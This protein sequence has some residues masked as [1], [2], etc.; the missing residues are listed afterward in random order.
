[1]SSS[2]SSIPTIIQ[3]YT[4]SLINPSPT[5]PVAGH[6][7]LSYQAVEVHDSVSS[8]SGNEEESTLF[9]RKQTKTSVVETP[10]LGVWNAKISS[11]TNKLADSLLNIPSSSYA[12]CMTVNLSNPSQVEPDMA[13]MQEALVRHLI[14]TSSTTTTSSTSL[15]QLKNVQFGLAPEDT[16]ASTSVVADESDR[17]IFAN[18][19]IC[20][21]LP[22]SKEE[23]DY[24]TTQAQNLVLYHV[25]RFAAAIGASL[26]FSNNRNDSTINKNSKEEENTPE[27]DKNQVSTLT[28]NQVA[29]VWREFALNQKLQDDNAAIYVS[30]SNN[31][32]ELVETVL[33]RNANNPPA[34]NSS[35]DS[36]WKA[37]PA[38]SNENEATD[39]TMKQGSS[40]NSGDDGWLQQL[41]DS[42]G[43]A[44]TEPATTTTTTT[45]KANKTEDAEVSSFFENLLKK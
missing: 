31:E 19:M 26:V 42:L 23:Q 25:R 39:E 32:N 37:L 40:N 28:V 21:I 35:T 10:N 8:S 33:L 44:A 4:S 16:P 6:A 38:S 14:A 3:L 29:H 43:T 18:V 17:K 34:W 20:A 36:L 15:Y 30:S 5:K 2:S 9:G 24:Q 27:Q 1:M 13:C 11:S 41:R 45:S 12:Y 7:I 22:S